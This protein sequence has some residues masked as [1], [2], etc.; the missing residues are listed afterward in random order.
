MMYLFDSD[1]IYVKEI[2]DSVFLKCSLRKVI[3]F[4][5]EE[6]IHMEARQLTLIFI[7]NVGKLMNFT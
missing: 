4:S 2:Y 5:L 1:I 7:G 3:F 6:V